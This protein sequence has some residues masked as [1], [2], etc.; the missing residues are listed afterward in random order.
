MFTT[1]YNDWNASG[2]EGRI[3]D[4]ANMTVENTTNEELHVA[5]YIDWARRNDRKLL[6]DITNE[7]YLNL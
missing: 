5:D 4:Y 1:M 7:D 3:R 2:F 6:F